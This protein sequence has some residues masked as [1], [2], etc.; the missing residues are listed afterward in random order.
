MAETTLRLNNVLLF[1]GWD[2]DTRR[3]RSVSLASD[4]IAA[5]EDDHAPEVGEGE[6]IDLTGATLLPGLI[7]AHFHANSPT[8]NI[9]DADA[10]WESELAQ[11]ARRHLE[12]QLLRGFTT[13][14][15]AE[16]ADPGI[17]RAT[18]S[19]LIHG[20]RLFVSG[21]A[22]S[23]T[24][25]HGDMRDGP[26]LCGC[27]GYVGSVSRTL[28]GADKIRRH[29]RELLRQ[30]VDQI[31]IFVSGGVLSPTDP[32]WMD[33]F[34]DLEILAAVEEAKRRRTYVMAHAHTASA[35]RRCVALGVRSIEHGVL[36]DAPT[37]EIVAASEA[38]VVPTL[39][40]AQGLLS[41][42]VS[43][44]AS[45]LEKVKQVSDAAVAAVEHGDRAGVRFGLGT[46]LFG[47]LHGQELE[48]LAARAEISGALASLRSATSINAEIL[49][50][51]GE[52]GCI[53]AGARADILVVAGDPVEDI[54][55]LTAP[56]RHMRMLIK[57]GRIVVDRRDP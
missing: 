41:E 37:A 25:G 38:Y 35:I 51:A 2:F 42:R 40:V 3:R 19:G 43:L 29:V 54:R 17:A 11:H 44:P 45:A 53:R 1:D 21:R 50:R 16:G 22:I 48:E 34:A 47:E 52:L 24:G 27:M 23:Q 10:M 13:V 8:L 55:R 36:M 9:P 56:D 6:V 14:R 28:D 57:D 49:N 39:V 18:A 20:P 33:Q 12:D 15:D 7:D 5:V 46:D 26:A 4:R 30:G 31:K 32:I